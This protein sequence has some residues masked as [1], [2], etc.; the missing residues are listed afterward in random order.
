MLWIEPKICST[1]SCVRTLGVQFGQLMV[2]FRDAIESAED[3]V[4]LEMVS[5]QVAGLEGDIHFW[6][7]AESSAST[8]GRVLPTTM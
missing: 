4:C 7:W 5:L 3:K 6:L 8:S 1:A 2:F